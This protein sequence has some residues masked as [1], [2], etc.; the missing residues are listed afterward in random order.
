M[1]ALVT[2]KRMVLAC[3]GPD[4]GGGFDLR[5]A[6]RRPPAADEIEVA[7]EAASVNPI[8]VAE[9]RVMGGVSSR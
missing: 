8:D 9:R 4:A 6:P 2:A 7:V 3:L 1:E 5:E